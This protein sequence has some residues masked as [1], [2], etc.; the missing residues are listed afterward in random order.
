LEESIKLLHVIL[1]DFLQLLEKLQEV[2]QVEHE[3]LIAYD[4]KSIERQSFHKQSFLEQMRRLDSQC[5]ACMELFPARDFQQL[6]E[7]LEKNPMASAKEMVT[8]GRLFKN[9]LE[10]VMRANAKNQALVMSSLEHI[11]RMKKNLWGRSHTPMYNQAGKSA[12]WAQPR[13]FVKEI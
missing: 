2:I 8:I 4:L 13:L 12:S 3:A 6:M 5:M 11:E 7:I 9:K 10:L 1:S